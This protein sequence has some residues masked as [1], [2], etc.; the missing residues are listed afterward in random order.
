MR[1]LS[2]M[3]L[4][5][6]S[7]NVKADDPD[8]SPSADEQLPAIKEASRIGV[9]LGA[10]QRCGLSP[11]DA[12]TMMKLGFARV[13]M[14]A[15]D[16]DVYAK[17]AAV[18]LQSQQ[19]GSSEMKPPPGGCAVI[20]P[21]ASGIFGNLTYIVARADPDVPDLHRSSPL[22]NLAAWS[23]QLAV[24]ASHCEAQDDVVNKAVGFAR[25]YLAKQT[26]DTRIQTRAD[27]E[28]SEAMLQTE[29]TDKANKEQCLSVLI[30]FGTFFGNLDAR[31]QE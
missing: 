28:L 9:G 29:L 8:R 4:M 11:Q 19:Y 25:Q 27:T 18:L 15:K 26:K 30:T 14:V 16:K 6:L 24:M 17:A 21:V 10:A 1:I 2:L 7:A 5:L 31:L 3:L 20:L 23:G 13:Q 12:D 22:E